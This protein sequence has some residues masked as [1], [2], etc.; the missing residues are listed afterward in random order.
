VREPLRAHLLDAVDQRR[1]ARLGA[2]EEAPQAVKAR[3]PRRRL[4]GE[5]LA[6]ARED[7]GRRPGL[8]SRDA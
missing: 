7:I 8:L 5:Q 2:E 3:I 4:L 1:G 6:V